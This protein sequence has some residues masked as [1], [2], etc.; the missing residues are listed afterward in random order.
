MQS[1]I[2]PTIRIR[3]SLIY[4]QSCCKINYKY[5]LRLSA[6]LIF[7]ASFYACDKSSSP[8]PIPDLRIDILVKDS[9]GNNLINAS[10]PAGLDEDRIRLMYVINGQPTV[11]SQWSES[12]SFNV[13]AYPYMNYEML[14]LFSNYDRSQDLRITYLDWGNGDQDTIQCAFDGYHMTTIWYNGIQIDSSRMVPGLDR[15]FTLIK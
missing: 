8:A 2:L 5:M 1:R 6:L 14:Q 10:G 11:V 4:Q 7:V 3:S 9:L 12:C 13:C 15:A